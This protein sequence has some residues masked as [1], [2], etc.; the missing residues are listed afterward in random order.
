MQGN[1]RN[2]KLF[3]W[4]DFIQ[5]VCNPSG[6]IDYDTSPYNEGIHETWDEVDGPE[7]NPI[8]FTKGVFYYLNGEVELH[9]LEEVASRDNSF[10]ARMNE[11]YILFRNRYKPHKYLDSLELNQLNLVD[12][13]EVFVWE[14]YINI[15]G[16]DLDLEMTKTAFAFYESVVPTDFLSSVIDYRHLELCVYDFIEEEKY[17]GM[18]ESYEITQQWLSEIS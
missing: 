4:G 7:L 17:S 18:I 3:W 6:Y 12:F 10:R 14:D 1:F 9:H 5:S 11:I 16:L 8:L 15:E 13:F 2:Y